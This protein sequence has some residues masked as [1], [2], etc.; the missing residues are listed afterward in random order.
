MDGGGLGAL[1]L[2]F[3]VSFRWGPHVG[4]VL[5]P[6]RRREQ[7]LLRIPGLTLTWRLIAEHVHA[8]PLSG[9]FLVG[10][11][12]TGDVADRAR[13]VLTPLRDLFAAVFFQFIGQNVAPADLLPMLP[14]VRAG[15]ALTAV[16]TG[17]YVRRRGYPT[18]SAARRH[19]TDV[20]GEFSLSS[21]ARRGTGVA[22]RVRWPPLR[23]HPGHR[24]T[25]AHALLPAGRAWHHY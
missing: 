6:P 7:P 9:R 1:A 20:C 10:L 16:I 18:R 22:A 24:R 12:L 17:A 2:A 3:L 11:T 15:G 14:C 25:G 21:S 19:G 13:S 5:W 4:R 8:W 23:L